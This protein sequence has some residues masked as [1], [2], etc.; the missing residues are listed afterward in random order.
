[1]RVSQRV[2]LGKIKVMKW[3]YYLESDKNCAM[4]QILHS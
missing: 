2:S 3:N 4:K 1:M